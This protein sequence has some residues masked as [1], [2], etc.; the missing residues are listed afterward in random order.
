MEFACEVSH[1]K[2]R[3]A[4]QQL[5]MEMPAFDAIGGTNG[6]TTVHLDLKPCPFGLLSRSASTILHGL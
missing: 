4:I 6:F 3:K 1:S 2:R 5:P